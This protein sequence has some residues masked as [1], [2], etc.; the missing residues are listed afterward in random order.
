[1][2]NLY[3]DFEGL[4]IAME[5]ESRG[6]EFYRQA[7][8]QA[9]SD[10]HKQL[11]LHLMEEEVQHYETFSAIFNDISVQKEAQQDEYLFDKDTSRYL[12]VLAES[13]V[14][15]KEQD[16]ANVISRLSTVQAILYTAMQAEKDSILFY[17]EL[18][19]N[20]RF[21]AARTVFNTLRAE[22]QTHVV[23]LKEMIN[24]WL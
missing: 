13:H 3:S 24:A 12:T 17:D 5:I 16:A 21:E 4:R 8:E 20:A 22:E 11:F 18:A 1:M 7:Y 14:F 2:E 15:P 19:R 6:R 10:E 9:K 23:K